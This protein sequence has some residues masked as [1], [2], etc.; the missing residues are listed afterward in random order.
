MQP[1]NENQ[2][3][4]QVIPAQQK[5]SAQTQTTTYPAKAASGRDTFI[6]PRDIVN[7][8]FVHSSTA[9]SSPRKK[10]SAP[11]TPTEKNALLDSFSVY[12]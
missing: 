8:S 12:A 1:V 9:D 6:L 5:I 7:L 10:P 3:K 4:N 11:V 2:I